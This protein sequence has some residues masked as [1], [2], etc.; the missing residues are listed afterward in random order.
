MK[1]E[2][3]RVLRIDGKNISTARI[4][5]AL[6]EQERDWMESPIEFLYDLEK[7]IKEIRAVRKSFYERQAEI[8]ID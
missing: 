6:V 4:A 1:K 5:A 7:H 2:S 8:E 3:M